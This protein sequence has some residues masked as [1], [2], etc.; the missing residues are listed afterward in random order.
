[1]SDN[2][3]SSFEELNRQGILARHNYHSCHRNAGIAITN[4]AEKLV[5]HGT[6]VLGCCFY[7]RKDFRQ[8]QR[9]RN[10]CLTYG[11]MNSRRYGPIGHPADEVGETICRCLK[12]FG[13]DYVW[14]GDGRSKIMIV[15]SSI[16]LSKIQMAYRTMLENPV[17]LN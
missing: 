13:V 5:D 4:E 17:P 2:L 15:T 9:G 12:K 7:T 14:D 11:P 8:R 1:M 6:V 16:R 10:F 3:T